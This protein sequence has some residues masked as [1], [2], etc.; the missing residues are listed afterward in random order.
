MLRIAKVA[1]L[2]QTW[3]SGRNQIHLNEGVKPST[4]AS[5]SAFSHDLCILNDVNAHAKSKSVKKNSKRKVWKPTEKVFTNIGYTWRP[6]GRT[7]TVVGNACP[8]TRITTTAEVPLMEPTSLESDTPKPMVRISHKTSVG[9]SPQ[10]NSVVKRR[11][12]TLIEFAHTMLIYAKALLFLWAEAVATACY[13]QNRSIVRL[14]HGKTPYELL[15]DKL[16]DLSFFNVFGLLY[17]P[18]NDSENFGK[19]QPKADIG[20]F[21]GNVTI[22]KEFRIYNQRTRR[23]IETIHVDFDELTAMASEH[24][25]SGP[26]LHEMTPVTIILGLVPNIPLST[27]F[28]PPLRSYWDILF[29]PLFDEL[30]TPPPSVDNP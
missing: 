24:S 1:P 23:I 4:S 5:G 28:V 22:K 18:T 14:R 2:L 27:P 19:L 26:T 11:N 13:T 16:P 10:Q 6:T 9:R 12:R 30:L 21:I 20:I 29:Q 8:L 7:F 17:Y 15:C 25:C 3:P